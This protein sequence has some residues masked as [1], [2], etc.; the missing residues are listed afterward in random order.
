MLVLFLSAVASSTTVL[1]LASI[2]FVLAA[3]AVPLT[4]GLLVALFCWVLQPAL[5]ERAQGAHNS[6]RV[7][8][9]PGRG[10]AAECA[11]E[12]EPALLRN[13]ARV[14]EAEDA[15]RKK[16]A[17]LDRELL[18]EEDMQQFITG[19]LPDGNRADGD[20][21]VIGLED[22]APRSAGSDVPPTVF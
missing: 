20:Q 3:G 2:S 6:P 7:A 17:Y 22:R 18:P 13:A 8:N 15:A 14:I 9:N 16:L 1:W 21:W 10:A 11:A 12:Q 19:W 4:A 5:A